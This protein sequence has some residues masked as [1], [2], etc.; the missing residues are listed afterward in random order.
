V[1]AGRLFHNAARKASDEVVL[2][3]EPDGAFASIAAS[4][5][6]WWRGELEVNFFLLF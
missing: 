6:A 3:C 4:M 2:E 1:V 5:Y